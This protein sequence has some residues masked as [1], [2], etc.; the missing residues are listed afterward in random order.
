[1]QNPILDIGADVTLTSDDFF[2]SQSAYILGYP[3]ALSS[4]PHSASPQRLPIVKSCIISGVETDAEGVDLLYIDAVVNPGFSGGPLVYL[5]P[6]T[7]TAKF[8][9]VVAKGMTG[10]ISEPTPEE[11][12]P[13]RGPAGIGVVVKETTFRSAIQ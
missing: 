3:Y 1:M 13:P 6:N 5:D 10:P 7:Q 12:Q 9:G 2:Y 8:A 11:P 4:R